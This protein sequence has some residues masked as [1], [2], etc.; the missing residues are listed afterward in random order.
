MLNRVADTILEDG[1]V[2]YSRAL[3]RAVGDHSA[4]L[5][6]SLFWSWSK[7]QPAEREGWF[8]MN[9]TEIYEQ[10]MMERRNQET[11][12]KKLRDL[13][14]LEEKLEGLPAKLWF[15]INKDQVFNLL[16]EVA[17]KKVQAVPSSGN[18]VYQQAGTVCTNSEARTVPTI[19]NES[20]NES[21]NESFAPSAQASPV[22]TNSVGKRKPY[23]ATSE[24]KPSSKS[25]VRNPDESAPP[26]VHALLEAVAE[27]EG[28]PI[29]NYA[30]EG[31]AAKKLIAAGYSVEELI[32]AYREWRKKRSFGFSLQSFASDAPALVGRTRKAQEIPEGFRGVFDEELQIITGR[33][34]P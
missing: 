9:R 21:S 29:V 12:R 7:I 15:R 6:L 16:E 13:G 3:A 26:A 24:E 2:V 22:E 19:T 30:K 31:A 14:I 4:G 5:L 8:Y 1:Y 11:A 33:R 17:N 18:D 34:T 27:I 32:A 10:T 23:M 28:A 25:R 20:S